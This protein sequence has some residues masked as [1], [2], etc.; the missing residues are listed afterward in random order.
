MPLLRPLLHEADPGVE[1]GGCRLAGDDTDLG[2]FANALDHFVDDRA[3]EA[4]VGRLR[5]I[6]GA[7]TVGRITIAGEELDTLRLGASTTGAMAEASST[8]TETALTPWSIRFWTISQLVNR[9]GVDRA[10]IDEITRRAPSAA[11]C[12]RLPWR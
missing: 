5:D 7:A 9:I 2:I 10:G 8:L 11:R 3:A 6:D 12:R 4:F 1:V